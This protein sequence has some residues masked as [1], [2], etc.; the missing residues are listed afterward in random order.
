MAFMMRRWKVLVVL[1]AFAVAGFFTFWGKCDVRLN[2]LVSGHARLNGSSSDA[3]I[4]HEVLLKR[5]GSLEDVVYRQL[6]GHFILPWLS[7]HFCCVCRFELGNWVLSMF[8]RFV[9]ISW[10]YWGLQRPGKRWLSCHT[11]SRRRKASQ[12]PAGEVRLQC[13]PE[14][15]DF[16]GQDYPRLSAQQVS[17][18]LPCIYMISCRYWCNIYLDHWPESWSVNNTG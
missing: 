4:S 17:E 3:S 14:W 1:N 16:P 7:S 5:L 11:D 2:K 15:Q 13:V 12:I 9:Q 8:N 10:S 18:T 6:N